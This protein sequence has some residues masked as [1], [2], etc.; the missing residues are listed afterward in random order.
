[1]RK[2]VFSI[3]VTMDGCC[4]HT[5]A[6]GSDDILEYFGALLRNADVLVYGRVT[7]Q[8][9]V[10]FWPDLAK[11]HS[12]PTGAMNDFADTFASVGKIVVFSRTLEKPAGKNTVILRS[13]LREEIAKLKQEQGKDILLG[14][15]DLPS[16]LLESGL[17][18]EYII[19]VHPI[20]AGEGRR[21]FEGVPLQDKLRLRLTESKV[22]RSGCVALRYVT[23]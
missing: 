5:K 15:V 19:V 12:A 21:L 16:Q 17:I 2:L 4:D 9:M 20:L 22:L 13:N 6:E 10:P 23:Q 3:N 14:G 18:D 11:H 8:L 1:M 7:Y